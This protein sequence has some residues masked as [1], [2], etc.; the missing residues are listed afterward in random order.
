MSPTFCNV[1]LN[2][3]NFFKKIR[4]YADIDTE[5]ST[6]ATKAMGRNACYLGEELVAL[7]FF[8]PRVPSDTKRKISSPRER[9]PNLWIP[10]KRPQLVDSASLSLSDLVTENQRIV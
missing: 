10:T 3:L 6:V 5:T 2:D 9:D 7:A 1:P 8:D 4:Y